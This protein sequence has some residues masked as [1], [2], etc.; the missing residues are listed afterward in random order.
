MKTILFLFLTLPIFAQDAAG[1]QITQDGRLALL[2]DEHGN[3]P[4]TPAFQL[5]IV[6]Q[7]K[8]DDLGYFIAAP[9][10]E[11]VDLA[12]GK[13]TRI[14]FE[15]GYA[16][17]ILGIDIAP[18]LGYGRAYRWNESYDNFEYSIQGKLPMG[19]GFSAM[20]LM[21]INRRKE[22]QKLVYNVGFGV[23]YDIK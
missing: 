11:Y 7:S 17:H 6:L 1:L 19:R 12:G 23:R 15:I 3:S 14:G 5:K 13:L 4:F 9:K 18:L 21:N 2:N 22:I 20:A 8:G 16:F 10:Y